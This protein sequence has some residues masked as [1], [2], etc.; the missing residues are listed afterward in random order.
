MLPFWGFKTGRPPL[1][2]PAALRKHPQQHTQTSARC[3]GHGGRLR[4]PAI[5]ACLPTPTPGCRK[6]PGKTGVG[7]PAGHSGPTQS[8]E[9][10]HGARGLD[11]LGAGA[12]NALSSLQEQLRP[13][14]GSSPFLASSCCGRPSVLLRPSPPLP[15]PL[16]PLPRPLLAQSA[17]GALGARPLR[18]RA[19][20]QTVLIRS[21]HQPGSSRSSIRSS[22]PGFLFFFFFSP[23]FQ[24]PLHPLIFSQIPD[25]KA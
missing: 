20:P 24:R 7:P 5:L 13:P 1:C 6:P 14:R 8:W 17:A 18:P 25:K 4:S 21:A 22:Q 11:A 12:A 16:G 3:P 2:L 15:G 23:G 10:L 9:P 19:P